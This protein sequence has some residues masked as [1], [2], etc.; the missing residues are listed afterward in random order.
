MNRFRSSWE[1]GFCIL[2]NVNESS[3]NRWYYAFEYI[4]PKTLVVAGRRKCWDIEIQHLEKIANPVFKKQK[5][6][7]L[8]LFPEVS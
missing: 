8:E 5:F 2:F 1:T 3:D 7:Q 6:E 4:S